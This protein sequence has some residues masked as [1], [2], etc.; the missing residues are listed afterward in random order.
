MKEYAVKLLAVRHSEPP[1]HFEEKLKN[2]WHC[3]I[4][5][6]ELDAIKR[7]II[8]A[9]TTPDSKG[10][11]AMANY[12]FIPVAITEGNPKDGAKEFVLKDA[13]CNFEFT[14]NIIYS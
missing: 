2:G 3:A 5:E 13:D 4:A 10:E 14:G 11:R 8:L 12:N 7:V 1:L 9:S 6:S